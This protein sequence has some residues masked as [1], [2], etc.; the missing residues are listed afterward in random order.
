VFTVSTTVDL[1]ELLE[2][3][4]QHVKSELKSKPEVVEVGNDLDL[5][6]LAVSARKWAQVDEVVAVVADLK[7]STKLSTGKHAASTASIYEAAV[8]PVVQILDEFDADDIDIQGDCGIGVFWGFRRLER[9]FCA[10]VTIK[11]FSASFLEPQ[12]EARWPQAPKT[13]FKVGLAA[14]RILVKRVGVP[15]KPDFQEEVWVGKAVNYAA[16]AAQ[17]A[18][19]SEMWITG[20][21]WQRLESNDYIAYSCAC[22]SGPSDT[23]WKDVEIARLP[24]EDEDRYGRALLVPWCVVHG[25]EFCDA[26]LA[27]KTQRP[28]VAGAK[29]MMTQKQLKSVI[30]QKRK[31][32]RQLRVARLGRK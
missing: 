19:R 28:D 11:T 4:N 27:G 30:A 24:E 3:A 16:K 20:S 29:S 17:C 9:A 15:R 8:T 22:S 2:V 32:A 23:L 25:A 26:I 5:D 18:E 21:A 14:S 12:L 13:G 10:G 7:D 6:D 31:K 1:E